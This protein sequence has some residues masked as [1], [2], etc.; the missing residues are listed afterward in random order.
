MS[1]RPVPP[2]MP[3]GISALVQLWQEGKD[4]VLKASSQLSPARYFSTCSSGFGIDLNR[5]RVGREER[6]PRDEGWIKAEREWEKE[7][8][9]GGQGGAASRKE[10][11][12]GRDEKHRAQEQ[13]NKAAGRWVQSQ[14]F[15]Q[16]HPIPRA[17]F[18]GS[19]WGLAPNPGKMEQGYTSP[20]S[21]SL[22]QAPGASWDVCGQSC[23]TLCTHLMGEPSS[24]PPGP[25]VPAVQTTS[26]PTRALS[27][28][29]GPLPVALSSI[30]AKGSCDL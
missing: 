1:G 8:Q 26:I 18:L 27:V 21:R 24:A 7:Q 17:A 2:A 14:R 5:R 4:L 19:R 16:G 29:A 9:P 12:A 3:L 10:R 20:G 13:E 28:G 15:P 11:E 22:G 30:C 6:G 25:T 23:A